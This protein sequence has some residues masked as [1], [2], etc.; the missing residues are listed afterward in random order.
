[1]IQDY[2]IPNLKSYVNG[3]SSSPEV[4]TVQILLIEDNMGDARIV[5]ILLE[6][7]DLPNC[8][9]SHY[10]TLSE[11]VGALMEREFD[12]VLLDLSLPDSR[13]FETLQRLISAKPDV[14]VVVMT[15]YTDKALGLN[16]VK[17]GAQDFLMKGGFD[18]ELLTKTLRYAI[19]RK[20]VLIKLAAATRAQ[21]VAEESARMKEQFIAS[22]SHEMRTPMNAIYGMSN[23]LAQTKLDSEQRS[24]IDSVRQSSEI[25]LGVINDILEIS[26]LQNGK[27]SFESKDFDLHELMFNLV[28]VM[29]YKKDEKPLEFQLYIDP[30]VPSILKGDKLRLNQILFNIVG[31]A[32]KFTDEGVVK[33]NVQLI[34]NQKDS[35]KLQFV[36][37]DTGIGIPA[38]KI[39]SIFESF[40]R[41]RTKDRIYEGTGL[42]LAIVKNL[43][44]L[45]NGRVWAESNFGNGTTMFIELPFAKA[46]DNKLVEKPAEEPPQYMDS[47]VRPFR[48]LLVEDHKMNQ[49]VARKTLERQFDNIAIKIAENGKECL[50]ILREGEVFDIILMDIQMPIMDGT[51]T[52][53]F[54]REN[55][56]ELKTPVL[57][58]TA[59]A[60]I[61][62]DNS[63]KNYGFDDYVLKP[64]EPEQFFEKIHLYL[65]K[66]GKF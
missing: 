11:G 30:S 45:Q 48:L 51:E 42:G 21:E 29:Q 8:R 7:S 60:N 12:V 66:K 59:H 52:I 28:N 54:I 39:D 15:G 63:F 35:S 10:Q 55:M 32:V 18:A 31:N 20:N 2:N 24:Y 56:P 40:T 41:I 25:L 34:D 23:L 17:A 19:E 33:I 4:E 27:M 1:M 37:K 53:A 26:T 3:H 36:V 6:E 62:K 44:H 58:M 46:Q 9:I 16:A 13:G 5:E 49:I 47:K 14:N 50:D 61:S 65:D 43:V 22:I 38:D 57:A 64:F